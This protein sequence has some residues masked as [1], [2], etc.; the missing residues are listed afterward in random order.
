MYRAEGYLFFWALYLS[1][2]GIKFFPPPTCLLTSSRTIGS[3][4]PCITKSNSWLASILHSCIIAAAIIVAEL[5]PSSRRGSA[6]RPHKRR[7]TR[8]FEI[9]VSLAFGKGGVL[10][11]ALQSRH[12]NSCGNFTFIL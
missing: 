8:A 3:L 12:R 9:S 11:H 2:M 7:S 10:T 1:T 5:I 6:S 4:V